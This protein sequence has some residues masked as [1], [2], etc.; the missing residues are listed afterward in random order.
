MVERLS[1]IRA[2]AQPASI[3]A[4]LPAQIDAALHQAIG[5]APGRSRRLADAMRYGVC[6]GGKRFRAMLVAEVCALLG[7]DDAHAIRVG[8]AIECVH[9]QSLVHDDLPCM[10]DDDV[11]RGRPSLHRQFDEATAVLAGDALL[12]LAFEM[13][14]DEVTHP[15]PA[16]R[17]RLVLSLARAVGQD[18]LAGGQMMDLYPAAIASEQQMIDCQR[19][20]TGALIRFAVDAGTMLGRCDAAQHAALMDYADNLGLAFQVRDDLIDAVGDAALAGKAVGKDADAGRRSATVLLGPQG[21]AERARVLED[22]CARA[23]ALFGDAAAGL[24]A[25]AR[26]AVRRSG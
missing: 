16:V 4:R 9:A 15:D 25:L 26:F 20:K 11:R 3:F 24:H 14:A 10:D 23:L 17:A 2:G 1:D 8:A 21:A 13:L 6:G 7:G 22:R 19:R 12:A 18:G 5:H